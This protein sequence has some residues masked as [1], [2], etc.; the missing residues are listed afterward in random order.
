MNNA[1]FAFFNDMSLSYITFHISLK[2]GRIVK[3]VVNKQ[4]FITVYC[5]K[6]EHTMVFKYGSLFRG[7]YKWEY[8]E[9]YEK[10]QMG[11]EG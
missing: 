7:K 10:R 4:L 5:R 3:T 2:L 11:D 9:H 6:A 1:E 8:L